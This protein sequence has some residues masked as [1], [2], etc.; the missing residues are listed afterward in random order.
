MEPKLVKHLLF[1]AFC[2]TLALSPALA[3]KTTKIG[4]ILPLT[5]DM[6]AV[7]AA[8]RDAIQMAYSDVKADVKHKYK[9]IFED[10]RL[11]PNEVAKA[12]QKLISVDKVSAII[13]TWSYGGRIVAPLAERAKIPH[14]G[15]AWD[16]L[17]AEGNYNFLHLTPPSEFMRRFLDVFKKNKVKRV[18]LLGVE[19]SGSV[20]ALDEFIRLAPGYGVEVVYRDSVLWDINDFNS[21]VTKIAAAKPEYLLFNLGGENL[22][23]KLLKS[24]KTQQVS[25]KY[26]AITS[27]DVLSNTSLIEGLWYVSDSYLPEEFAK[28]FQDL[29]GHTIRYG[30]GNYYEA[31]KLFIHA[32]EKSKNASS[33]EAKD[34]LN[35]IKD[36][37]SIFGST[38]VDNKGIFTYPAQYMRIVDGKRVITELNKID[39]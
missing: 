28:R 32:F 30:V 31:L 25:F 39:G 19:E 2:Y 29:Y 8:S 4:V 6:A 35:N 11:T 7:G 37:P 1:L 34:I 24:L 12:A 20:F 21:L 27:F 15:V 5:G 38:S 14:I 3:E 18:A 17:V 33:K 36:H 13:S 23:T 16:H 22:N 9:I 26:T 10:D